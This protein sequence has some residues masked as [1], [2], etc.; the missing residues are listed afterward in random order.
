[1]MMKQDTTATAPVRI[2]T[3]CGNCGVV[4]RR[5]LHHVRHRGIFRRLCT[6]CVLRLHPQS[7]CPTCF[8]VYEK[9]PPAQNDH[10]TCFKCYSSSHS[11]CVGSS[12]PNRYVCP[13]CSNPSALIFDV[14]KAKDGEDCKAIDEKA[15]R[16]LLA[17]AKI[18]A[19]S[20]NKAA[21]VVRQE[22]EKRAKEAAFARKRAREA[23]E[24]I[25]VLA[26]KEK[27]ESREVVSAEI[28]GSGNVGAQEKNQMGGNADSV[29]NQIGSQYGAEEIDVASEVLASLNAVELREK[30][31]LQEFMAQN[32]VTGSPSCGVPMSVNDNDKVRVSPVFSKEAFMAQNA[33]TGSPS[34]GVPMSVKESDKMRVSPVFGTEALM[35]QNAVTGSSSNCVPMSV[36]DTDKARVNPVF[37]TE[38]PYAQ[39]HV[40][41]E[42]S[43][44]IGHLGHLENDNAQGEKVKNVVLSVS[45]VDQ[46]QH[47]Q[48]SRDREENNLVSQQ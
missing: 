38:A 32:A 48:N 39:N 28:L 35:A 29:G 33:V 9:S 27:L 21:V 14:K 37:G 42:E 1:M 43:E 45:P 41:G 7:F 26:V 6:S 30:E 20:M 31:R 24:H 2:P 11:H 23:M 17:A 22:A 16:V 12:I 40:N 4:E 3:S 8:L 25:A 18:A 15:A 10:V 5:L 44:R 19:V 46:L 36:K 13:N 47:M 34:N